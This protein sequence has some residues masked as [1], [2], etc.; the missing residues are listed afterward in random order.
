MCVFYVVSAFLLQ[1]K[2]FL[3]FILSFSL[4][5]DCISLLILH[6]IHS[7][8]N[9]SYKIRYNRNAKSSG[10][11]AIMTGR[12]LA[13][14]A[15]CPTRI[16]VGTRVIAKYRDDDP[17]NTTISGAFYVGIVAEIPTAANKYR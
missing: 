8:Q 3:S 15:S 12:Q 1:K 7:L 4:K 6:Y 17:K 11:T 2:I 14:Y 5:N 9:T 16:P 10:Q 13:Y